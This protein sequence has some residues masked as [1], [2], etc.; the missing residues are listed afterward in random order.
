MFLLCLDMSKF[1]NGIVI[2]YS[3]N[4]NQSE[5][6]IK[7]KF[8]LNQEGKEH[9]DLVEKGIVLSHSSGLTEYLFSIILIPN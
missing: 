5:M 4:E 7:E 2:V 9:W 8:D 3:K 1:P 6:R